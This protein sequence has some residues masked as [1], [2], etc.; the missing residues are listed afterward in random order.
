MPRPRTRAR[1]VRPVELG[2][3]ESRPRRSRRPR[4][5]RRPG[6]GRRAG[7]SGGGRA[8]PPAGRSATSHGAT[9]GSQSRPGRAGLGL[10]SAGLGAETADSSGPVEPGSLGM[11][12]GSKTR[13]SDS[14]GSRWRASVS[15][16][17]ENGTGAR[18]PVSG[19]QRHGR[20]SPV[21]KRATESTLSVRLALAR[22]KISRSPERWW[23]RPRSGCGALTVTSGAAPMRGIH[24]SAHCSSERRAKSGSVPRVTSPRS[25][26]PGSGA[27][28]NAARSRSARDRLLHAPIGLGGV[29][30][31]GRALGLAADEDDLPSR[32]PEARD[33]LGGLR[34]ERDD[35]HEQEGVVGARAV[36]D[37]AALDPRPAQDALADEVGPVARLL[38]RLPEVVVVPGAGDLGERLVEEAVARPLVGPRPEERH[39]RLEL[40]GREDGGEPRRVVGEAAHVRPPGVLLVEPGPEPHPPGEARLAGRVAEAVEDG[41]QDAR[42]GR[43][44]PCRA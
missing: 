13:R 39:V 38:Q 23:T 42:R 33:R 20:R 31:A 12:V 10:S 9:T 17:A 27:G 15:G 8:L 11:T 16:C 21:G 37:P 26:P 43:S 35:V 44:G 24:T 19:S 18:V 28:G 2:A 36:D 3:V 1:L 32:L 30:Q 5:R 41:V 14:S 22:K 25:S 4:D 6:S 34:L 40:G 29:L 7:G